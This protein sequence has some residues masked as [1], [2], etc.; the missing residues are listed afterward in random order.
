MH[1]DICCCLHVKLQT[2]ES[3]CALCDVSDTFKFL[4][5]KQEN[6]LRYDNPIKTSID[7]ITSH[8]N[9]MFVNKQANETMKC[10]FF[11]HLSRYVCE[12]SHIPRF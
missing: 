3:M 7:P 8:F 9:D 5:I 6:A 1:C 10:M 2:F 11:Q 12:T 4:H